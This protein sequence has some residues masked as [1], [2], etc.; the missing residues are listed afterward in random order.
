M[1][2]LA[3]AGFVMVLTGIAAYWSI[4]EGPLFSRANLFAATNVAVG[5]AL[6]ATAAVLAI[7]SFRGFSGGQSRRVVLRWGAILAGVLGLVLLANAASM[8]SGARLDLTVSRQYTLSDQTHT[9]CA[10]LGRD[11]GSAR[12]ELLLIEDALL[13]KD[14][15]LLVAAY[16]AACPLDAR[17][18][19]SAHAP[20]EAARLLQSYDTTVVACRADHCEYVGHPSEQ[21]ITNAL[22]RLVHDEPP[23]VYFGVGHGEAD[24]AS[25]RDHGFTALTTVLRNEGLELRAFMGPAEAEVPDDASLLVLAAPER[26]LLPHELEALDRYLARGG[27]LLALL[28]PGQSSNLIELLESWGF[29]LPDAIV[30][31]L[32][33]SPLLDGAV[34]TALV[35]NRFARSHAVTRKMTSRTMVLLPGVRP[36]SAAHKPEPD[37]S[38]GALAYSSDRSWAERDV[39]GALSGRSIRPDGQERVGA[40]LPL[41][42]AGRFPRGEAEARIVVIGDRDFAS[43]R[44]IGSLY[45]ADLI[46]NSILWLA[47]DERRLAIRP[48]AWT[49]DS[50]PLP[51]E[52]TL[53]YFYS[54]AFALPEIL[55]LLGIHAWYRQGS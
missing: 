23:R 40:E 19:N 18:F 39:Q 13:A 6:L 22:L 45:N 52:T 49:P 12:A 24:L 47:E 11:G 44:W 55:L 53:S 38:M 27:R 1:R 26:N 42:A 28:E 48:K 34:P 46:L 54:L 41:A 9:L 36:V 15:R 35:V 5:A 17:E 7:R 29:G 30:A 51:L 4:G 33:S 37:D 50:Q 25:E 43:N 31:D 20:P 3:G 10:Q 21:N 8:G 16:E 14:V 32:Q 2:F